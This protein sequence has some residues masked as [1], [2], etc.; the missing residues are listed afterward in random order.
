ML[1]KAKKLK[2]H[3]IAVAPSKLKE[4]MAEDKEESQSGSHDSEIDEIELP[5]QSD[6]SKEP[7]NS[8]LPVSPLK[9]HAISSH[10]IVS[11]GK[12]KLKQAQNVLEQRHSHIQT[13]ITE[14]LQV[15]KNSL[16]NNNRE[17]VSAMTQQKV[18]GFDY[19]KNLIKE[20]MNISSRQEKLQLLKLVSKT[21]K[22]RTF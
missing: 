13:K 6:V 21:W 12:K 4:T 3:H 1:E 22:I 8:T 14:S 17:S 9:T 7:L 19:L 5:F 15:S 11:Y 2:T 16:E 18:D 20:K 10:L